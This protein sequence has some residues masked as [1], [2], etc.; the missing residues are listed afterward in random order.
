VATSSTFARRVAAWLDEGE[1]VRDRLLD[2]G[3]AIV[4]RLTASMSLR[5]LAR[6]SYLSATYLSMIQNG[7]TVVSPEAFLK[8]AEIE[9]EV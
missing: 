7:R 1:A 6:R 5:G 4:G 3:K 2:E 8:L 9:R